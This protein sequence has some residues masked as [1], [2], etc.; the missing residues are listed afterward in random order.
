MFR[1]L[2]LVLVSNALAEAPLSPGHIKYS[3]DNGIKVDWKL[4]APYAQFKSQLQRHYERRD[5]GKATAKDERRLGNPATV[6]AELLEQEQEQP[7]RY[8]PFSQVPNPLKQLLMESYEAQAPYVDHEAF[9]HRLPVPLET[10]PPERQEVGYQSEI[11]R[12]ETR[13]QQSE[14]IP[15]TGTSAAH[16][17][18]GFDKS[19][20][21]EI[22]QLL[23]YQAQIPYNVIANHIIYKPEIPFVPEPLPD[24]Q[25]GPYKYR[26]RVYYAY[27]GNGKEDQVKPVSEESGRKSSY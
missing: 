22:Q 21:A 23:K 10:A 6:R 15:E 25:S 9:F 5:G 7:V 13:N 14:N 24:D 17:S 8:K 18:F 27:R 11:V 20:P 2:V 1:L 16:R 19:V 4:Y 26:S 3:D 12:P